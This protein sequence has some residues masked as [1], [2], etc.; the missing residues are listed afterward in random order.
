[1]NIKLRV[2]NLIE[3]CGT[4][5]LYKICERLKI[6]IK[7]RPLG[8]IKGFYHSILGNKFIVLNEELNEVETKIV[9]GHEMGHALLHCSKCTRFLLDNTTIIRTQQQESEANEFCAYLIE[10]TITDEDLIRCNNNIKEE[11]LIEISSF[12][13]KG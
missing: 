12:L 9:L 1:M 8:N 6:A 2:E 7:F 11:I 10:G 3:R 13:N 5:N 4:N